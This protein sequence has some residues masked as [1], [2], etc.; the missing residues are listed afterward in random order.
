MYYFTP[1]SNDLHVANQYTIICGEIKTL[2]LGGLGPDNIEMKTWNAAPTDKYDAEN[3]GTI[4]IGFECDLSGKTSQAFEVIVAPKQVKS[5]GT[6]L[7]ITFDSW[8]ILNFINY[9]HDIQ[10]NKTFY[11]HCYINDVQFL[12]GVKQ[13]RPSKDPAF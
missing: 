1:P 8:K 3:P 11:G 12:P 6:F 4:M 9:N 5:E 13:F 2:Y 10:I 7:N